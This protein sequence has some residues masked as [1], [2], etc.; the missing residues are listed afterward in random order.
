M[1]PAAFVLAGSLTLA[2]A[3]DRATSAHPSIAAARAA[4]A[5]AQAGVGEAKAAWWPSLTLTGSAMQW[6]EPMLV[7]PIHAFRPTLL[8]DFDDTLFQFG[9][10]LRSSLIDGGGRS[11]RIDVARAEEN[12]AR[13]ATLETEQALVHGVAGAYLDALGERVILEAHDRRIAALEAEHERAE[14]FLDAGRAARV[15]VL[16]VEATLA[17]ARAERAS[18]QASLDVA[19]RRLAR[20]IGT[21]VD[22]TASERLVVVALVDTTLPARDEAWE[23]A[24]QASPARVRSEHEL[25]AARLNVPLAKS[26][27]WPDIDLVGAIVDRGSS[28]GDFTAEW[29]AGVELA[30]PLFTGGALSNASRRAEALHAQAI[31]GLRLQDDALHNDADAAIASAQEFRARVASLETARGRFEEVAR[32]SQLLLE[33]GSGTQTDYLQAEADLLSARASLVHAR[34]AE[35]VARIRLARTLGRLDA[36]WVRENLRS[37]E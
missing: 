23:A 35:I 18:S 7:T 36:D 13:A 3:V 4:A 9:V 8:P 20:W 5:A 6:Q 16:R 27:R 25:E 33:T 34:A 32:V 15:D 12:A 2:D 11:A 1:T 37:L 28:S 24:L 31:E 26:A 21:S 30:L 22:E 14:R 29:N 10:H 19:T 17:S